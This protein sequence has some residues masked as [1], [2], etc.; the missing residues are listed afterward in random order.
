MIDHLASALAVLF[1]L[2]G[3]AIG[4][5]KHG[6][7]KKAAILEA[8]ALLGQKYARLA[9]SHAEQLGVPGEVKLQSALDAFR[10]IDTALDGRRDFTEAQA[11]VFIESELKK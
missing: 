10:I 4:F 8:R 7:A 6:V 5:R 1:S 11:R 9:V 2:A 3:L